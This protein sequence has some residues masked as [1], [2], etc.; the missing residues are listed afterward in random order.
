MPL[1]DP[2]SSV[3]TALKCQQL[4]PDVLPATFY[5]SLLF[6]V[7]WNNPQ[8]AVIGNELTAEQTVDEPEISFTPMVVPDEQGQPIAGLAA[9]E[10]T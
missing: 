3:V 5:P 2:L 10:A 6:S 4:I 7:I 8:E 1:L 9:A